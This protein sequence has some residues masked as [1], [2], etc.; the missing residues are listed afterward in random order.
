MLTRISLIV[1]IIAGL[2]VAVL[3]FWQVKEKVTTL[4][5]NLQTET[6]AHKKYLGL[7]TTT[8]RE[9]KKTVAELKQ[10]KATLEATTE[11]RDTAVKKADE[12]TKLAE[13]LRK[14]LDTTLAERNTALDKLAAFEAAGLTP[15]QVTTLRDELK[16]VEKTLA[17]AQAESRVLAQN[18][19]TLKDQ[20]DR[21]LHPE[22]HVTLPAALT[23]KVLVVDPKY[24]FVLLNIGENQH[25]KE[26]GEMLVNRNGKLVAKVIIRSMQKDR[27]IANVMPGWE[28][29][30]VMEG[31]QAIPAYPEQ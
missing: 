30:A 17:G 19:E 29:G 18:N 13:G 8:D 23:G 4:Q 9:L 25:A 1:A 10:T 31:D 12:Q 22:R 11:E 14:D 2:A 3:N 15:K 27:S 24:N 28:V 16:A 6:A 20:L 7:Y 5:T 26:Y 21:F